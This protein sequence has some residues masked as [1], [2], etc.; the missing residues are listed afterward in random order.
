[1]TLAPIRCAVRLRWP[2]AARTVERRSAAGTLWW[3]R[4]LDPDFGK[5]PAWVDL[6]GRLNDP[7]EHKIAKHDD[8][9]RRHDHMIATA[10]AP[11]RS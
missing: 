8:P 5:H 11:E 9:P 10:A 2:A 7:R 3:R 1:V 6:A 4:R